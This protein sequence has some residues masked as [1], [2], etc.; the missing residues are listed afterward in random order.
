MNVVKTLG[1]FLALSAIAISVPAPAAD[2]VPKYQLTVKAGRFTPETIEVAA[3]K[4]FILTVKN[5]G[6]GAEEFE[7]HDL[8]RE[9]VIPEGKQIDIAIGPLKVGTYKFVGEYHEATAKGQII[10]K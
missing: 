9:K 3:G 4:K 7:S 1:A 5:E 8:K 2:D 10:A 6:P